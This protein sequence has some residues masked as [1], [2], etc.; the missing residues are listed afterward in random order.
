MILPLTTSGFEP[1]TNFLITLQVTALS[2]SATLSNVI[3]YKELSLLRN[4]INSKILI[5]L[6]I[7]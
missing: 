3:Y 2:D 5:L 6:E 4:L 7:S 1:E